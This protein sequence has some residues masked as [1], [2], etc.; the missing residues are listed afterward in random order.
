MSL[1]ILIFPVAYSQQTCTAE[2]IKDSLRK[3]LFEFF[4]APTDSKLS[5]NE[6]KDFLHFYISTDSSQLTVDCGG[7]GPLS[8][9][10]YYLML[11]AARNIQRSIPK[12]SDGTE[13]GKCSSNVPNY[14]YR[15]RLEER[16]RIC[17]CEVGQTCDKATNKCVVSTTQQTTKG[18]GTLMLAITDAKPEGIE[19]LWVTLSN[20]E[21]NKDGTWISFKPEKKKFELLSLADAADVIGSKQL[22]SGKYTQIRFQVVSADLKLNDGTASSVKIPSGEIKLVQEFTIEEGKTTYLYIDFKPE[23]IV[24]AGNQYILQPVVKLKNLDEFK[25][26]LCRVNRCDDRNPCTTDSCDGF[27]CSNN[28]VQDGTSCGIGNICKAGDCVALNQETCPK[29]NFFQDSGQKFSGT[30]AQTESII[31]ADFD[32]DNDLDLLLNGFRRSDI[33]YDPYNPGTYLEY[34]YNAKVFFN[35]GKGNFTDT[36]Q[37]LPTDYGKIAVGDIDGDGDKDIIMPSWGAYL[38]DPHIRIFLNNGKGI[39]SETSQRINGRYNY[40]LELAD[41]DN[42]KDLD[43]FIGTG[44]ISSSRVFLNNGKGIFSEKLDTGLAGGYKYWMFLFDNDNDGDVDLIE[45]NYGWVDFYLD[46]LTLHPPIQRVYKNDG[47]GKFSVVQEI[48]GDGKSM[49]SE[50]DTKNYFYDAIGMF[51]FG[52][53]DKDGDMDLIT[54]GTMYYYDK[55]TN[56]IS[57]PSSKIYNN[58]GDGIFSKSASQILQIGPPAEHYMPMND[59]DSDGDL[60]F[61]V[62]SQFVLNDGKGNF[63]LYCRDPIAYG[64]RFGDLDN[65]GDLDMIMSNSI[66]TSVNIYFNTLK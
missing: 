22:T 48:Y 12:C 6:I 53:V 46:S 37:L 20:V 58:N 60:D 45:A 4:E 3:A 26:H 16:C 24:K 8:G 43:L 59:I 61:T 51:S 35:N 62:Y 7:S 34:L 32:N 9:K 25:A 55:F 33:T 19:E 44:H 38:S 10:P 39:F 52:D 23:S 21:V 2:E 5:V 54:F 13:Y 31:L 57:E 30:F 29:L 64:T 40:L 28:P 66:P 15:G 49:V 36:D 63:V 11:G 1:L 41:I 14:C 65:D 27:S 56:F 47:T 42:D 50:L 17:E 18:Q